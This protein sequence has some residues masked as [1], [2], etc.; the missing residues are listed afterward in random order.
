[1]VEKKRT[2]V[3][4]QLQGQKDRKSD[5]LEQFPIVGIG[6]SAGGLAAFKAFFAGL[7]SDVEPNMA[8]ILVQHLAPDHKS[9]LT[10]I[11]RQYTRMK[12]FVC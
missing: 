5:S 7:P 2:E 12:V 9:I 3:A 4:Q 8:F 10:E 11:V 1:M 6:A